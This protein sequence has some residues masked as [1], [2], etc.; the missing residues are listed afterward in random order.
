MFIQFEP[1]KPETLVFGDSRPVALSSGEVAY[2]LGDGRLLRLAPAVA[3]SLADLKLARGEEFR[4]C[5][6]LGGPADPYWSVWLAPETEKAR[7]EAD[8]PVI[9]RLSPGYLPNPGQGELFEGAAALRPNSLKLAICDRR[10]RIPM[11][12]AFREITRFVL[13]ELD[14]AGEVWGESARQDLVSTLF[15]AAGKAGWLGPWERGAA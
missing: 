10:G 4:I 2:T 1:N 13:A 5:L 12:V 11:N 9:S 6:Q 3:R 15:I 14:A 8:F 7:A